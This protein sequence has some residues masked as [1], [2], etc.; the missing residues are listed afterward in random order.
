MRDIILMFIFLL[1]ISIANDLHRIRSEATVTRQKAEQVIGWAEMMLPKP[2]KN[3][4]KGCH[5]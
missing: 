4:C 2:L 1:T 5:S 3:T